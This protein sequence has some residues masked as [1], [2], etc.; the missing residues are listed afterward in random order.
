MII[1][2]PEEATS[3]QIATAKQAAQKVFAQLKG[4][5]HFEHFVATKIGT[6]LN[7]QQQDLGWRK[8]SQLPDLYIKQVQNLQPGGLIGPIRAPNG[9]HIIKLADSQGGSAP[10][11]TAHG[12]VETHVRHILIKSNPLQSD[13]QIKTRIARLRASILA[14]TPFDQRRCK[15]AGSRQRI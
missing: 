8:L 1:P 11:T 2:L 7:L 14:G 10:T 13:E 4:N 3:E 12:M 6:D 9:F 5:T 15:F